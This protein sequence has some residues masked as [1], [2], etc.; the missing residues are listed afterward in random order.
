MPFFIPLEILLCT[1]DISVDE[2]ELV[3][4][5]RRFK[6]RMKNRERRWFFP[7]DGQFIDPGISFVTNFVGIDKDIYFNHIIPKFEALLINLGLEYWGCNP[8]VGSIDSFIENKYDKAVLAF[9]NFMIKYKGEISISFCDGRAN[10]EDFYSDKYITNGVS[11]K[12][13][14]LY[15]SVYISPSDHKLEVI[16]EF[17]HLINTRASENMLECFLF[18]HYKMIFGNH[19]DRIET[20]LWL[21]FPELDI[22]NKNRRIDLFLRNAI[23][24]DWELLEIKKPQQL[25]HKYRNIPT[26]TSEIYQAI[27]QMRSYENILQQDKVKQKFYDEGIEYFCPELRLVIGNKPDISYQQWRWLKSTNEHRLKIVT[28]ED[29]IDEMKMRYNIHSKQSS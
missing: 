6:R 20:Q 16:T 22:N 17:E 11:K 13:N 19:Y 25:T 24:R 10:I 12:S 7:V 21:R 15:D 1:K 14:C 4:S 3:N 26:F 5:L 23:E 27:Q 8:S 28:F 18:R 9:E 29:L 2:P